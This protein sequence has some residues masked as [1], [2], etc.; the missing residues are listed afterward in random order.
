MSRSNPYAFT[1]QG[2]AMLATVLRTDVAEEV[3][4][5][6]MRAFILMRKYISL[7]LIEQ[8]YINNLVKKL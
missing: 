5:R 8:K 1:E 6:I 2:D 3:S 7:S 4:V